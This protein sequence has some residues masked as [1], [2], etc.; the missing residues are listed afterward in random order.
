MS[1]FLLCSCHSD[2]FMDLKLDWSFEAATQ[3]YFQ[4][5]QDE[6]DEEECVMSSQAER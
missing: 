2:Y 6:D 5:A 3:S 4:F 1:R